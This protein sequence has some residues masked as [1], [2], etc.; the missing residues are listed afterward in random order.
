MFV[1]KEKTKTRTPASRCHPCCR[2]SGEDLKSG[3]ENRSIRRSRGHGG[4]GA[5]LQVPL[6]AVLSSFVTTAAW[7]T[8]KPGSLCRSKRLLLV[9]SLSK[10]ISVQFFGQKPLAS[11]DRFSA[12]GA[13]GRGVRLLPFQLLTNCQLLLKAR[14]FLEDAVSFETCLSSV[15]I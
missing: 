1:P 9:G 10:S 7:P 4:S 2:G 6:P 11:K 13:Y 5:R 12:S 14:C 8:T 15:G 3:S